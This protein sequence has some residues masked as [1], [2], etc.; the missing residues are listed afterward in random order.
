MALYMS[1]VAYTPAH[2]AALTKDP[3]DRT[4]AISAVAQKMGCRLVNFYYSMG[5]YDGLVIIEAPNETAMT[6]VLL[7]AIGAGHIRASK[8]TQLL[9]PRDAVEAMRQAGAAAFTAPG[10]SG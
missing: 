1:Q 9:A 6:A 8:T 4:E 7:A 5:E 10:G 3:Q 2:L